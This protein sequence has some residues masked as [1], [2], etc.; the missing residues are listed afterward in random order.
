MRTI[1]GRSPAR[2]CLRLAVLLCAVLWAL[3]VAL[4]RTAAQSADGTAGAPG[5]AATA[6]GPLLSLNTHPFYTALPQWLPRRAQLLPP[7]RL[8]LEVLQSYANYF[9]YFPEEIKGSSIIADIDGEAWYTSLAFGLGVS[10]RFDLRASLH[11]A[12]HYRGVLDPL[13]SGYHK[14]FGFPNGGRD[15][16]PANRL[17]LFLDNGSRV[18]IDSAAP[19]F[20]LTAL[21]IESR[22]ALWEGPAAP[23]ALTAAALMKIPLGLSSHPLAAAGFDAGLRFFYSLSSGPYAGHVSAGLARLSRPAFFPGENFTPWTVPYSLSLGWT[24]LPRWTLAATVAGHTSPFSTGYDRVD[25][26]SS[27]VSFG[28]VWAAGNDS[29]LQISMSQEFF[30]FAASDVAV[31]LLWRRGFPLR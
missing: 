12:A 2:S 5:A 13:I 6:A 22:L 4:P 10:D 17:R 3:C 14:L 19:F 28:F 9:L 24:A 15:E 21:Q 20:D 11:T 26:H 1:A 27:T 30:T 7:G 29:A 25:L 31:N 18:F 16:E 8:E 23:G